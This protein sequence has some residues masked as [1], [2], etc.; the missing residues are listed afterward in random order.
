M[1]AG[2]N[3]RLAKTVLRYGVKYGPLVFE[4]V[5]HG[6]EPAQRALRRVLDRQA[7]RG[8]AHRHAVT[9]LDGSVLQVFRDGEPIWIAFSGDVPVAAYPTIDVPMEALLEYADLSRRVPPDPARWRER[10]GRR[11]RRLR[12]GEVRELARRLLRGSRARRL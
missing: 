11:P 8:R 3:G 10:N 5:K 9:L 2:R 12:P 1:A 4:A 7:S 6:R